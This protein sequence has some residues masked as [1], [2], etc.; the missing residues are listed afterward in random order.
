MA[1]WRDYSTVATTRLVRIIVSMLCGLLLAQALLVGAAHA[2]SLAASRPALTFPNATLIR[3]QSNG[4]V[5]LY[6][7]GARHWI[8]D[9][10]TLYALGYGGIGQTPLTSSQIATIPQGS[11]LGVRT[12]GNGLIYPLS[13]IISTDVTLFVNRAS[14]VPGESVTLTCFGFQAGEAVTIT[15]PNLVFNVNADGGGNIS[16]TVPVPSSVGYGLHHIY[17]RG[18]TSGKFGVE[19]IHVNPATPV[20]LTLSQATVPHGA[21]LGVSGS[22]FKAGEH[23]HVFLSTFVAVDSVAT[24]AGVFGPINLL[25]PSGLPTGNYN[26]IAYGDTSGRSTQTQISL[27]AVAPTP[28]PTPVIPATLSI[29]PAS[30]AAGGQAV[31]SGTGFQPGEL[32]LVRINSRLQ[33]SVAAGT[34]GAFTGYLYTVPVGTA[35]GNYTFSISGASSGR[36]ASG[37]LAVMV[38]QPVVASIAISPITT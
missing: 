2:N 35:P 13:P 16:T 26:V 34:T 19:V 15:A 37:T 18:N 20:Q 17:V 29:A 32:I 23:V 33:G 14:V 30:V 21:T 25:V 5:Y 8:S 22:G 4:R 24:S 10:T 12:V 11:S 1:T 9:P 27:T 38:A 31:L 7:Q 36:T 3:D 28:T 6:W